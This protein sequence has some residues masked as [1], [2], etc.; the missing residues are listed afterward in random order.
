MTQYV[1][2][3]VP[4]EDLPAVYE[5]L[6]GPREAVKSPEV[7][8]GGVAVWQDPDVVRRHLLSR[9]AAIRDLARYLA[10][11]PDELVATDEAAAALD[12]RFGWN[13]LA[14]ALG[15]FGRYCVNRNL[16]FPW[17]TRENMP[18]ERVRLCLDSATAKVIREVLGDFGA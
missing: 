5:L 10:S 7:R 1:A 11:R 14:G 6:G 16:P 3:M 15:A 2:V 13:S 12:L 17:E 9:S 18:D 8:R 4:E